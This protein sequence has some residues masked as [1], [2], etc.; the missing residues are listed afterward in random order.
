MYS[1]ST[2]KSS[3]DF[4]MRRTS[5]NMKDS[6]FSMIILWEGRRNDAQTVPELQPKWTLL[7]KKREGVRFIVK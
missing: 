2:R 3:L 4:T 5:H 6:V 1:R 7:K